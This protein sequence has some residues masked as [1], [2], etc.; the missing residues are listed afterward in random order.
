MQYSVAVQ[1]VRLLV[2]PAKDSSKFLLRKI[3]RQ[4]EESEIRKFCKVSSVVKKMLWCAAHRFR[5]LQWGSSD[6]F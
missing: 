2:Q 5:F 3:R 1:S 6:F 4:N